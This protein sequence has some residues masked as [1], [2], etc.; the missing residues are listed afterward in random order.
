MAEHIPTLIEREFDSQF[1][2]IEHLNF[3][4][5]RD[6]ISTKL[7]PQHIF[8]RED[9]VDWARENM[10]PED[11]EYPEDPEDDEIEDEEG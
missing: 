2:N 7:S 11:L 8:E 10:D 6:F 4:A 9:L 5:V 3:Q 1:D